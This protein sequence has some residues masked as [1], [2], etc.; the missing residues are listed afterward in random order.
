MNS[1]LRGNE[2]SPRIRVTCS[3]EG[4]TGLTLGLDQLRTFG[5]SSTTLE[6]DPNRAQI[7]INS[8]PKTNSKSFTDLRL[9]WVFESNDFYPNL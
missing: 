3:F 4:L 7:P 8:N 2:P 5:S 6:Q 1:N 9:N